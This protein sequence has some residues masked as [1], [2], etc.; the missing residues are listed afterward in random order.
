MEIIVNTKSAAK[1]ELLLA[2]SN[3]YVR[4]LK[5]ERSRFLVTIDLVD[6]FCKSTGWNGA[7]TMIEPTHA[8]IELDSRLKLDQLLIT[9]AHEMVHVKQ[10]AKGQ[11]KNHV[12]RTGR[13]VTLWL[14]KEYK[15][16][17]YESPWEIEAFSRERLL[18]NKVAQIISQK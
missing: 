14:G 4:L 17:Y 11:L 16:D 3:L 13:E 5:I 1:R 15:M 6:G 7:V 9:L 10:R 18:A 12:T 8:A 2:V